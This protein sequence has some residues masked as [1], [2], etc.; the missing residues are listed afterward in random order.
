MKLKTEGY[1]TAIFD[2]D[3]V[4]LDSNKIKTKAFYECARSYGD[5]FA[6]SLVN[7]HIQNGGISR[8]EKFKYFL[9]NILDVSIEELMLEQLLS[10]YSAYVKE[11]LLKCEIA[12]GLFQL[13]EAL[14]DQH[15]LVVSGG[16]QDELRK[17]F[18]IRSLSKLFDGGIFGSP[19]SKD[20]IVEQQLKVGNIKKPAV[21]LGDSRYDYETASKYGFDFIFISK[22]S[23]FQGWQDFFK[24]KKGVMIINELESLLVLAK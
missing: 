7:Y 10:K 11:E 6:N 9:K 18:R 3:G 8:Y 2:C 20:K 14:S 1:K 4:I 5:N 12:A 22:Y 21:F 24:D 16:D 19:D 13:R 15:W 23:E 17:I